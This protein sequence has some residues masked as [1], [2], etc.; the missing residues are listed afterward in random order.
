MLHTKQCCA[1]S[2]SLLDTCGEQQSLRDPACRLSADIQDAVLY[3]EK[4]APRDGKATVASC[5]SMLQTWIASHALVYFAQA[6]LDV[7]PE[8]S[9]S[10]GKMRIDVCL[11]VVMLKVP[12]LYQALLCASL[13][14]N[15]LEDVCQTSLGL[16]QIPSVTSAEN[17]Q[18]HNSWL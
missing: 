13:V 8:L 7:M 3:M 10:P 15:H 12:Q 6:P 9:A 5:R 18:V 14:T 16:L 11:R 1:I 4:K 17:C 2:D